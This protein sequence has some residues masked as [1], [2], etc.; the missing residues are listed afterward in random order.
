MIANYYELL[1]LIIW[2]IRFTQK[3]QDAHRRWRLADRSCYYYQSWIINLG[4]IRQEHFRDPAIMVSKRRSSK[5]VS[6]PQAKHAPNSTHNIIMM[7]TGT[8]DWNWIFHH[9]WSCQQKAT[10]WIRNISILA[11]STTYYS[12]RKVVSLSHFLC[13]IR[14]LHLWILPSRVTS[15]TL[16]QIHVH[17]KRIPLALCLHGGRSWVCIQG[18]S[19]E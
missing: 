10:S 16:F 18:S 6:Q 5:L 2:L 7:F 9:H 8:V 12:Y 13:A 11:L 1:N 14:N 15:R 19:S 4:F 3:K 17:E